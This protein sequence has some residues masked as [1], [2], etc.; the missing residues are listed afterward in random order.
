MF[1]NTHKDSNL[2]PRAFFRKISLFIFDCTGSSLLRAS[3][4]A[5]SRDSIAVCKLLIVVAFLA[6]ERRLWA[7]SLQ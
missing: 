4:V 1:E 6:V 3:L 5:A 7:L 2:V